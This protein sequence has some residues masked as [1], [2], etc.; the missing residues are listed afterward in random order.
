MQNKELRI[1]QQNALD[2]FNNNFYVNDN[3]RGVISMCCGSG[4]SYTMY[5]IIKTCVN[6]Y[7]ELFFVIVT[8]RIH[9]IEQLLKDFI[10]WNDNDK[11]RLNIKVIGG[12]FINDKIYQKYTMH[13]HVFPEIISGSLHQKIPLVVITTYNS[14]KYIKA[15]VLEVEDTNVDHISYSPNL[16]IFD[17]AHNTTGENDGMFRKLLTSDERFNPSKYLFMTATPV[18]L[19]LKNTESEFQNTETVYTMNNNKIYGEII[20]EYTFNEGFRDKILVPFE[21]IYYTQTE[22]IPEDIQKKLK[23]TTLEYKKSVYFKCI[24]KFL[25]NSMISVNLKKTLVYLQNKEKV[26]L[27]NKLLTQII[28]EKNLNYKVYSIVSDMNKATRQINLNHFRATD[29]TAILLSVGIFNEGVD[30]PCIDSVMFAE[31]KHTE[32]KIVQNIGRCLRTY[33]AGQYTKKKSYVIIPNIVYEFNSNIDIDNSSSSYSSCYKTIRNVIQ[34]INKNTTNQFYIRYIKG[35]HHDESDEETKDNLDNY[36][37]IIDAKN[38]ITNNTENIFKNE[39]IEDIHNFY[40]LQCT[41]KNINNMTLLNLKHNVQQNNVQ[42]I[43]DYIK[44]SEQP[45]WLL[46][47]EFKEDWISWGHFFS[48]RVLSYDDAKNF[49]QTMNTKILTPAQWKLFYKN[50]LMNEINGERDLSITDEFIHTL[51]QIPNRLK[52]YYKN[53]WKGWDDFL[54]VTSNNTIVVT[55]GVANSKTHVERNLKVLLNE[56]YKK[57]HKLIWGTYNN[58]NLDIDI[59]K[60]KD[61]FD[62]TYGIDCVLQIKV[63]ISY[64]GKYEK[65][66]IYG[67]RANDNNV[68]YPILIYPLELRYEFDHRMVSKK[69]IYN[70]PNNIIRAKSNF[71]QNNDIK[72]LLEK[73][74]K[75]SK[76]YVIKHNTV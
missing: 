37:K 54:G 51:I 65:C 63:S 12:Q 42:N 36:D 5:N 61:F 31:E 74:D 29:K 2:A 38:P 17:E 48:D 19:L 43:S 71:F 56:D 57:V 73:I 22:E 27:V 25:I 70:N 1:C 21:T 58:I 40:K 45:F 14:A 20:Y 30:E 55:A 39:D 28:T 16:I 3:A 7:G 69:M 26:N 34:I 46:H 41:S 32:S 60:I 33:T 75:E 4:K 8:S 15:G 47:E 24:S 53:E 66:L 76:I 23:G 13:N 50:I 62:I 67:R 72:L 11:L 10:S 35:D 18:K 68:C 49:I 52:E 9:L 64:K 59:S 6:N 44:I